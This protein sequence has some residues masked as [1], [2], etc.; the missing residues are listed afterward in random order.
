M[1]VARVNTRRERTPDDV[2]RLIDP[3]YRAQRTALRVPEDDRSIRYVEHRPEHFSVPSTASDDFVLVEITLF[4][5]RSIEAKTHLHR[6]IV[7]N[8]TALGI[9]ADDVYVILSEQAMENWAVRGVPGTELRLG[10]SLD[11]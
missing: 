10:F 9:A 8:V 5:G 4:P 3:I 7:A 6:E 2:S 1:P 11:V